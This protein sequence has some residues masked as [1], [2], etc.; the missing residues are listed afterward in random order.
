MRKNLRWGAVSREDSLVRGRGAPLASEETLPLVA[1]VGAVAFSLL[2]TRVHKP[3]QGSPGK[4]ARTGACCLSRLSCLC[5]CCMH[6]FMWTKTTWC[7]PWPGSRTLPTPPT[8]TSTTVALCAVGVCASVCGCAWLALRR[9]P[10]DEAP[11]RRGCAPNQPFGP[12]ARHLAS[13][14]PVSS[15]VKRGCWQCLGRW[16]ELTHVKAFCRPGTRSW[17]GKK[18]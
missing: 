11:H 3:P 6:V 1:Q 15:S 5:A 7:T 17:P 4:A 13:L 18:T 16:E 8:R 14:C 12:R 10:L 9:V 2:H